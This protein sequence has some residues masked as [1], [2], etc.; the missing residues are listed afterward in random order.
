[1]K[2]QLIFDTT[3]VDTIAETDHVGAHTLSGTGTLIDSKSIDSENWLNVA[4]AMFAGN[5][6]AITESDGALDVNIKTSEISIEVDLDGV[7]SSP[8]NENPDSSGIIAHV[9]NA[10][11]DE[12]HQTF[13]ST[14]GSASSDAVVAANVH[15][16]DVNAFGM[17]Y[18]GTTWDRVQ[19]TDGAIH[20]HDGGNSITVDGEVSID[21]SVEVTQGTSP[22]VVSAT[23]LDIRDLTHVSD[24]IRLGDGTDLITSTLAG[25]KQ[26]LDVYIA[27][28]EDVN[29]SDAA[30]A[31]TAIAGGATLLT[32]ANTAQAAVASALADRKY[33][34]LYNSDNR[35]MHIGPSGVSE[36]SGF[37][38]SPG[39][40]VMLRAGAAVNV[41]FVSVKAGHDLRYLELS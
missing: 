25:S 35:R 40:Y 32:T 36:A 38:V 3:S 23:D 39:S 10:S 29:V 15:G 33:L 6:T 24:S 27:G 9:R 12:S 20:I 11:P 21:G 8:D 19:G 2:D 5:G 41:H 22:W 18:N 17:L 13:R 4:A 30:L 16:L 28:S 14:G 1:M 7:Y 31:E 34:Y 37:P 26:A